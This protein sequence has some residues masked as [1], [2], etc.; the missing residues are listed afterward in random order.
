LP[1]NENIGER[2][3]EKFQD[4]LNNNFPDPYLA[5]NKKIKKIFTERKT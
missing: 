3:V 2:E 1:E 5:I 4:K